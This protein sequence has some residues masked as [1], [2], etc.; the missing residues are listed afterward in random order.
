M[1]ILGCSDDL[2]TSP[3]DLLTIWDDFSK[4][5]PEEPA[6]FILLL[7]LEGNLLDYLACVV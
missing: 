7:P 2:P 3:A 4:V 6:G 1:S 5:W